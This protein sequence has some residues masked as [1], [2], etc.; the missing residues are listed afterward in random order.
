MNGL[1]RQR[2]EEETDKTLTVQTVIFYS[3]FTVI[4][5]NRHR[6]ISIGILSMWSDTYDKIYE[7]VR[8]KNKQFTL[9]DACH[10][11]AVFAAAALFNFQLN[12]GLILDPKRSQIK[13][14]IQNPS[15]PRFFRVMLTLHSS[16]ASW[17]VEHTH[18]WPPEHYVM[19]LYRSSVFPKLLQCCSGCSPSLLLWRWVLSLFHQWYVTLFFFQSNYDSAV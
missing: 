15:F 1:L 2:L 12:T 7:P 9:T 10:C 14:Q 17:P 5:I 3:F 13:A 18:Y 8:G 16:K 6:W 4:E 11:V 19:I